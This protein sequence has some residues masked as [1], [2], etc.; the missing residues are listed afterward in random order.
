MVMSLKWNSIRRCVSP[1]MLLTALLAGLAGAVGFWLKFSPVP[2]RSCQLERGPIASEVMGTGTLEAR[3]NTTVSPKIS[4]RIAEV[5]VDQNQSVSANDVL[6]VLDDEELKQQVAIAEAQVAVGKAAIERLQADK[7]RA[8][9]VGLQARKQH[10][11]ARLL[12][13]RAATSE[14]ELDKATEA[15]SVAMAGL[16]QAEAAIS[17]GQRKLVEAEKSLEYQCTRL[18]DTKVTAPFDGLI[19]HRQRETGDVVAPGSAVLSL[20]DTRELWISAW[21]DE[22]EMAKL[23]VGQPARVVFRSEPGQSY[24]GKVVRLGR[25]ADRETREFVVDVQVLKLPKNWAVGQRA[26]VFIETSRK[27]N[28]LLLPADFVIWHTGEAGVFVSQAGHAAWRRIQMGLRSP[29]RIEVVAGIEA[30]D[31]AIQPRDSRVKVTEGRR[32]TTR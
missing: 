12:M 31:V 29:D 9:A 17:E 28:A 14:Q 25:E 3:V 23:D 19:V 22:T 15:L 2:V 24:P 10:D 26:E 11:R 27:T 13:E 4:G 16:S 32:I 8:A 7:D 5:R 20:I 21:I 1:G 18:A 6:F 30:G